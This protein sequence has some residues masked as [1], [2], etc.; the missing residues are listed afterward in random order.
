MGN[1]IGVV[2]P[3]EGGLDLVTPD[4]ILAKN[5]GSLKKMVNFESAPGGGY[6]RING[7]KQ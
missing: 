4:Y 5:P 7:Y 3:F 1:P 6:R 2:I